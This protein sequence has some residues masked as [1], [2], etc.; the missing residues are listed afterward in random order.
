MKYLLV[1]VLHEKLRSKITVGSVCPALLGESTPVF[2]KPFFVGRFTYLLPGGD[3]RAGD[4]RTG[5]LLGGERRGGERR[6][7]DLRG[8]ERLQDGRLRTG[9]FF[10]GRISLLRWSSTNCARTSW[11]SI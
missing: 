11:P 10:R 5:D 3:L 6:P 1:K 8:E 9:L 2:G 7:G 4:L